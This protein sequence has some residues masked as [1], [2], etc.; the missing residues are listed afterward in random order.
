MP[1]LAICLTILRFALFGPRDPPTKPIA[2][3][4]TE[5]KYVYAYNCH[6]TL[7]LAGKSYVGCMYH[8]LDQ[9]AQFHYMH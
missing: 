8:S 7:K 1:N 6:S 3:T 2:R 9:R 5:P 4:Q